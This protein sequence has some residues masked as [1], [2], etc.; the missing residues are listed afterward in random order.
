MDDRSY[1]DDAE[2]EG[3]EDNNFQGNLTL[4]RHDDA[5]D[6]DDDDEHWAEG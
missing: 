4:K 6:D 3:E 5:H 1:S 2:S